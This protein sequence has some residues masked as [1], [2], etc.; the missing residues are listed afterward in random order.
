MSSDLRLLRELGES[1]KPPAGPLPDDLRRRVLAEAATTR[2]KVRRPA[3][4]R[5]VRRSWRLTA[6]TGAA[7]A[8]LVLVGSIGSA[9]NPAVTPRTSEAQTAH[10]VL[11]LAAGRVKLA[12]RPPARPDQ[13]VFSESVATFDELSGGWK[14]ASPQRMLVREW[15]PVD[16]VRAGL[17]EYRLADRADAFWYSEPIPG[18]QDGRRPAQACKPDPGDSSGLP[19][20]GRLMYEFLYRSSYDDISAAYAAL[21]GDDDLAFERAARTLY[22]G[23]TSPAVQAAV[24]AAMNRIPGVSVRA[25][26]TDVTGRHGV[27]LARQGPLG[28]TELIFDATTYRYLGMNL[29]IDRTAPAGAV[30]SRSSMRLMTRQAIQR[31]AIVNNVGDLP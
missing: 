7:A 29:A 11:R 22:L 8:A 20:D 21:I 2:S 19:T 9:P 30:Q 5:T 17:T 1:L 31:V 18:C 28:T 3:R 14:L 12:A 16:G 23:Q 25:G 27:A 24:F 4:F 10:Q 26:A 15:R 6:L 13:F